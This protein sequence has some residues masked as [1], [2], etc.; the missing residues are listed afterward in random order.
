MI[1]ILY[2]IQLYLNV[3][4]KT[5]FKRTLELM[6]NEVP[7]GSEQDFRRMSFELQGNRWTTCSYDGF[8]CVQ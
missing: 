2:V 6:H 5:L 3:V 7:G 8:P 4:S 1:N